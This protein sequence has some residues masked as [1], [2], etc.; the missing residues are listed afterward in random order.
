MATKL[1]E[2]VK[3]LPKASFDLLEFLTRFFVELAEHKTTNKMTLDN[4]G[5]CINPNLLYP[6][7]HAEFADHDGP[8]LVI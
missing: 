7:G 3:R 2:L 8:F 5:I 4:I 1:K 6:E